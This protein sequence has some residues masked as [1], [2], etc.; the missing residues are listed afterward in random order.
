M[1]SKLLVNPVT[2]ICHF[3][4]IYYCLYDLTTVYSRIGATNANLLI[5]LLLAF[6]FAL[7]V[8]LLLKKSVYFNASSISWL[9]FLILLL[10]QTYLGYCNKTY[11]LIFCVFAIVIFVR[12]IEDKYWDR[13][14]KYFI[15]I[16]IWAAIG[17]FVQLAIPSLHK[18]IISIFFNE[19][20]V[21]YVAS[22]ASNGYYSGFFHQVGDTAFYLSIGIL[23]VL[24]FGENV[25]YK[26]ILITI[27]SLALI[28]EGKR[29][30]VL[31]LLAAVFIVYISKGKQTQ[32]INRIAMIIVA[33][34]IL[35]VILREVSFAFSNIKFFEKIAY[36][37]S[38]LEEG[39][40]DGLLFQSGRSW[41]YELAKS[42][43]SGNS[44]TGIG[45]AN[46]SKSY[47]SI[48][49]HATSVHNIYLQLLC[50]TGIIGLISFLIGAITSLIISFR[51]IRNIEWINS[52]DENH[53]GKL[54]SIS[55]S[56]QVLF[57]LLGFVENPLYNENCLLA[58][59]I[60][61][62]IAFFLQYRINNPDEICD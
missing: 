40:I 51:N 38:Y 58:Y 43:Y 31:F 12:R 15:G 19:E 33:V 13:L 30:L 5:L 36:T 59:L 7:G 6:L 4:L 16:S 23:A 22:Y 9:P 61:V 14:V 50:E 34:A 37:I 32:K 29:S 44:L 46:F 17:V 54:A 49:G 47:S 28:V 41:I 2:L 1:K 62:I 3:F 45:W 27:L 39:N 8:M 52:N 55:L 24:F 10:Y 48:Y 35:Y 60:F 26:K 56:G 57:L 20:G 21:R 42:L 25:R 53:L 18:L 11:F